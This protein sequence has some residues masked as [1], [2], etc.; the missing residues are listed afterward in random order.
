MPGSNRRPIELESIALPSELMA[1]VK[2]LEPLGGIEPPTCELKTR[3]SGYC[4][5]ELQRHGAA[6][7]IE[8]KVS[9][10]D[11]GAAYDHRR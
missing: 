11:T 2:N 6:P 3:C 9:I 1:L 7:V 8:D 5:T 10:E 4:P